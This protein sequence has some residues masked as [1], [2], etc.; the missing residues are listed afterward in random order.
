MDEPKIPFFQI[1]PG[2]LLF[3]DMSYWNYIGSRRDTSYNKKDR[4][5]NEKY[6]GKMNAKARSKLRF[7][8]NLLVAQAKWKQ[9]EN[10]STGSFYKFKI[11]FI[12]LTLSA[13]QKDVNDR[14]VKSKM[15]EPFLKNM[16]NVYGLRSYVWRAERQKN[17]NIHFH[18]STDTFIPFDAIR[19]VWNFQ[20]SKFHFIT[21]FQNKNNS[22]FPNSTDIHSV[23]NVKNLASYLVKYMSKD[24]KGLESIKGKVWD[25]S[26][27]LKLTDRVTYEMQS[28]DFAL[29]RDLF[30]MY[31]DQLIETENCT[32]FQFSDAQ[33]MTYLPKAYYDN[34]KAWLGRVYLSAEPPKSYR[35]DNFNI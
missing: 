35:Y 29:I 17:G 10:P 1:R 15:L 12:T 2:C 25:C 14:I 7:A 26:L 23:K 9:V 24:E 13:P 22:V 28:S 8:I 3:Y 31:P 5:A 11:N 20:Q 16:R 4:P 34:Y 33:M 18:I 27:N 19:D 6:T 21:D 32:I 30:M